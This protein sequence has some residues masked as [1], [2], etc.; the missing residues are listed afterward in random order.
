MKIDT[1]ATTGYLIHTIMVDGLSSVSDDSLL[2]EELMLREDIKKVKIDGRK[3]Y[4]LA[5]SV[6]DYTLIRSV[7]VGAGFKMGVAKYEEE[8]MDTP[9]DK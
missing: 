7:V 4:M 6:L 1:H 3:V 9:A 5:K 2:I 8:V